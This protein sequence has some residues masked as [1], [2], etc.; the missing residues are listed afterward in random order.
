MSQLAAIL[1]KLGPKLTG[2]LDA[3]SKQK[4]IGL[5]G[6]LANFGGGSGL[7]G[8]RTTGQQN[9]MNASEALGNVREAGGS[10]RNFATNSSPFQAA[11]GALGGAGDALLSS[12]NPY[13][14]AG[15]AALK[16]AG[17][18]AQS[19]DRLKQWTD[20]LHNSNMQ[21]AEFSASMSAVQAQAEVREYQLK[22]EQGDRRAGSAEFLAERK[23]SFDK[24]IAPIEN[25]WAKF[26]NIVG[27]SL[28]FLL[29]QILAPVTTIAEWLDSATGGADGGDTL[30]M[31][32][33]LNELGKSEQEARNRRPARLR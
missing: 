24:S 10:V 26:Q 14:M 1:G 6:T 15:G 19:V 13:A 11:G 25:L 16:L 7:T 23:G 5:Q 32:D 28:L 4:S 31:A 8:P 30:T 17:E 33:V 29:E 21:F 27:G 22:R 2:L 12:G 3:A 18:L 9:W 20:G